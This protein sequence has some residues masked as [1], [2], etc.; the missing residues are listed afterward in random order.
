MARPPFE[1]TAEQRFTVEAASAG[2]LTHDE[3]AL[4]ISN[5]KN[6]I[7]AKTLR[8]HFPDELKQGR[9]KIKYTVFS[10][11]LKAATDLSHPRFATMNIF[12]QKAHFG[13]VEATRHE[14]TG[15]DGEP[16]Q[17]GPQ[18]VIVTGSDDE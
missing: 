14:L 2:G 12:Y 13:V 9:T 7:T 8:K 6:P 16:L 11:G 15:A 17:T 10:R 1:P 3:I 4:L 5:K 18:L